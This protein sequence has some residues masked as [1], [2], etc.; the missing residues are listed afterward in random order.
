MYVKARRVGSVSGI[1][2]HL[3][4][5]VAQL[6]ARAAAELVGPERR[7]ERARAGEPS[8]LRGRDCPTSP[9]LLPGL[10]GADDLP[11]QGN[12]LHPD[13]LDPLDVAH[14]GDPHGGILTPGPPSAFQDVEDDL[15][16]LRALLRAAPGGDL[17]LP[18]PPARTGS[19]RGRISR[20]RSSARSARIPS[21]ST[22]SIS[23]PGRTRSRAGS[24]STSIAARA[25]TPIC[26]SSHRST[27]GPPLRSSSISPTSCRRPSAPRSSCATATTSTTPTSA[28]HSDRTR[29]PPARPHRPAF[30]GYDRRSFDERRLPRSRPP[31]P[32]RRRRRRLAR[33]RVRLRRFARRP[34]ARRRER[35]RRLPDLLRR[36][37]R[38][39]ARPPRA[40]LRRPGPAFG[41][42]DRSCAPRARRV[43]RGNA[44]ASSTCRSTSP[45]S[46]TST[47]A[48]CA[49]SP[50]F[51]TARSSPT[52]SLQRA[53]RGR[54]PLARSGW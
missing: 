23:A 12:R 39:R 43:L 27:G 29:P 34:A 41:E 52:A 45:C 7:E 18:R 22:A 19:R 16:A 46:P 11:G 28:P 54:V 25:P 4:A 17:R 26:P 10:D 8:Q 38:A 51:R 50:G 2:L 33:C 9:G 42:A 53:P 47:A 48:S 40:R 36:R 5:E 3:D 20:R 1:A 30:A 6:G 35:A 44:A 31:F 37:P 49:S 21:W 14:D 24:R 32:R 13:E 15:A